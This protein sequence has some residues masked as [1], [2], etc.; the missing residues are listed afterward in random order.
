MNALV[1]G[2]IAGVAGTAVM[3]AFQRWVEMPLSGR[4]ESFAPA[5]L[6]Q[7]LLPIDPTSLQDRRR[8]NHA[9]H[10]A[11]GTGWGLAFAAASRAGLRGQAAVAAVFGAVYAGDVAL[12]TALG[13]YE[14]ITRWSARDAIVDVVDKL[15][16]AEAAGAV[17]SAL[18]R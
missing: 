9:T 13:V 12:A 11:L 15:V 3:T 5:D 8:L 4:E 14:P 10:L 17:Y 18:E 1:R 2:T 6:A 16:L 7:K